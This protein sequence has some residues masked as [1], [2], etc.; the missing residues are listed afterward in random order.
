MTYTSPI[1]DEKTLYIAAEQAIAF[2]EINE[3]VK[4]LL[5]PYLTIAS[6]WKHRTSKYGTLA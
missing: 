6:R 4:S 5:V 1:N 3:R 2:S